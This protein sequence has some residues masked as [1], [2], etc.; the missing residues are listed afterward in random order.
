MAQMILSARQKQVMAKDRR[1]MIPWGD[2]GGSGMDGQF[3]IFGCKLLHLE[4]MGNGDLL[5]G[6]GNCVRLGHFAVQ[7]ELKKYCTSTIL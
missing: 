4:W 1:L 5:Y 3:G 7:Q 6:T 2:G